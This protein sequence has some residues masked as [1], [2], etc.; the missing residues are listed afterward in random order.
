MQ[1]SVR[2]LV[3]V[4]AP[5]LHTKPIAAQLKPSVVWYQAGIAIVDSRLDGIE[6]SVEEG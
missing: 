3:V 6:A 2:R 5:H 4:F 1:Y